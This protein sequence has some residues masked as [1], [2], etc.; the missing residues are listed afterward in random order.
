MEEAARDLA[1][2]AANGLRLRTMGIAYLGKRHIGTQIAH[3]GIVEFV[4][5]PTFNAAAGCHTAPDVPF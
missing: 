3:S 1:S 5:S 4:A 2:A